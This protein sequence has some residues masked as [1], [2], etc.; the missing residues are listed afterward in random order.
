MYGHRRTVI[1]V[2]NT[3]GA[4]RFDSSVEIDYASNLFD[5]DEFVHEVRG[6]LASAS[7]ALEVVGDDPHAL[8]IL[9]ASLNHIHDL[10][11]S[12][13]PSNSGPTALDEHLPIAVTISDP[14][15]RVVLDIY[16]TSDTKVY[17][18]PV[19]FRQ[20]IVNLIGNALKFSSPTST[21]YVTAHT[22]E[23]VVIIRVKDSGTGMTP[24][25]AAVIFEKGV[26]SDAHDHLPGDGL[27]LTIVRRLARSCGG[28]ARVL[29]SDDFGSTFEVTLPLS[30]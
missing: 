19:R 24:E 7:A 14:Q 2:T 8:E 16:S 17:C 29:Q 6:P 26:R 3:P 25:D 4:T 12:L 27:G 10:L 22:L 15:R 9:S 23:D 20:L 18:T 28:E 13:L 30:R 5:L 21:V 11:N 1:Y